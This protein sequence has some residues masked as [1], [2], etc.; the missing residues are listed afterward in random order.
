M[1]SMLMT[2]LE[3]KR[4]AGT[5]SETKFKYYFIKGI[6]NKE[7]KATIDTHKHKGLDTL[8]IELRK[9]ASEI[10][11]L[12][13]SVRSSVR[14][15]NTQTRKKKTNKKKWTKERS[16]TG[17]PKDSINN[18]GTFVPA[19]LWLAATPEE[20]KMIAKLKHKAMGN[21]G[22]QYDKKKSTGTSKE[23]PRK[24]NYTSVN[25]EIFQ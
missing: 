21:S 12:D 20:Q 25:K 19:K 2:F 4:K 11:D 24:S 15:N 5:M 1:I 6:K 7:Y 13:S 22:K 16:T 17:K 23:S 3:A 8:F 9:I 10:G 18:D 14:H